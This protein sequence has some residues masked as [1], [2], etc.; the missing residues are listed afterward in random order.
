MNQAGTIAWFA[1]HEGRLAWRDWRML[2]SGGRRRRGITLLLG[3][4]CFVLFL[5]LMA[6]ASLV[7]SGVL[8]SP[9]DRRM[10]VV[11][12]GTLA[13]Y[14]SLMLSQAMEA[15]T[16]AFYGRGDLDLI[17]SSPAAAWRVFAVRIAA[18]AVTIML[19][20]LAL[21]APVIDAMAWLGGANWL[22]A[23]AVVAAFAMAAVALA[24]AM[25]A[26]M[27]RVIGPKRTRFAAQIASAI[28]GASFVIGIQL[29]AIGS[30][31]TLSRIAVLQSDI[32]IRHAPDPGSIL[33]WPARAAAGDPRA[34][35]IVLAVG[36]AALAAAIA[37][38]A[39][40]FGP[41][42]LA[43]VGVSRKPPLQSRRRSGFRAT[44]PA[45]ALRRKE[46]TLLLRDPWL[47]SQ[48]LMQLLYLLPP[49]FLLYRSFYETGRVSALLVPVLIMASGQL[50]G[51]LA[52]LAISGEDAPELIASAPVTASQ[53]LRAKTEAVQGAI[54]IVFSPFML[55]LAVV[56]PIS[57]IV[58]AF[59]ITLA[60]GSSMLIQFWFRAQARRSQ[61]RRRQTSS[62]I[63]T[64]AEALSSITWAGTGA[65]AAAG[66]TV[67][68]ISAVAAIGILA[69]TWAISPAR[70]GRQQ[71]SVAF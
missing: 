64:I 62:R 27:F 69:G 58:I 49:V 14:G 2:L 50:A 31:G 35:V 22:A 12:T 28:I 57:A 10:L 63:A 36:T 65:L 16:R 39:R 19:M 43:T 23:Y 54:I 68:V 42:A 38:Y 17:L 15:V 70:D 53:V 59:G 25:T 56:D 48:S 21:A 71:Q 4:A 26:W 5:H 9:P 18:M 44:S 30:Y 45:Q 55:V 46:W 13:L 60:A 7:R 33:W 47:M 61:F 6:Y 3:L 67:A 11:V 24:V 66:S 37:V 51:G 1:R 41:F 8:P 34:L 32:L 20:S 52:W 29:A 40:R